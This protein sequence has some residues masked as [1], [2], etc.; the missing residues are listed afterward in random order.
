M[1]K[2]KNYFDVIIVDTAMAILIRIL[3]NNNK[4]K[5]YF[6]LSDYSTNYIFYKDK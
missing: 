1:E 3:I 5:V 6:D 4:N 2:L